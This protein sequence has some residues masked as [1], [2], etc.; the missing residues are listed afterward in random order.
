EDRRDGPRLRDHARARPR[1]G[2][3]VLGLRGAG[4]EREDGGAGGGSG[5]D[6]VMKALARVHDALAPK[7]TRGAGEAAEEG[8]RA[9]SR[10]GRGRR[11]REGG[12]QDGPHLRSERRLHRGDRGGAS[13]WLTGAP[14]S[15]R[16]PTRCAPRASTATRRAS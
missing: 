15:P 14:P 16:R 1:L 13:R 8:T 11:R 12:E 9:T 4:S 6:R 5:G 2:R 3:G 10:G 7:G